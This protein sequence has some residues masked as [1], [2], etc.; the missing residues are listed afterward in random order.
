MHIVTKDS[1]YVKLALA[2][3]VHLHLV[4]RLLLFFGCIL[5]LS[6]LFGLLPPRPIFAV[7]LMC[8]GLSWDYLFSF[9]IAGIHKEE[10]H[11]GSVQRTPW[12]KWSRLIGGI[13]FLALAD[14]P[15]HYWLWIY[16]Q[17]SD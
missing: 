12:I 2:W 17:L 5:L 4:S 13:C 10:Y 3:F 8:L 1:A 16:H 11:D 6:S 14:A 15:T 7:R 9:R